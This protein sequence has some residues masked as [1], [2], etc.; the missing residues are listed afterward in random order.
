MSATPSRQWGDSLADG[1]DDDYLASTIE[2]IKREV[3]EDE[4]RAAR[5]RDILVDLMAEQRARANPPSLPE[6][7]S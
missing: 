2:R 4:A 6:T 3:A 1:M 5:G 7:D